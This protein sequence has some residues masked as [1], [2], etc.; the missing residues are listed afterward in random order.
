M[1]EPD[2]RLRGVTVIFDLD[3]TLVDTAH[4]ILRALN[5][6]MRAD[7]LADVALDD[8]RAM[9]GRGSRRLL[10]RAYARNGAALPEPALDARQ[11]AFID[12]YARGIADHSRPFPGAE[13]TLDTLAAS[14]AINA[15]ATNKPQPLTTALI[16][17]LGWRDRFARIVGVGATPRKKPDP[18]HLVT[19]AGGPDALA[20]AIMV[21]DSAT[22]VAA[23]RAANIPVVV[24][25]HGYTETPADNLGADLV[26]DS[27]PETID[28]A[29]TLVAAAS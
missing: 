28:A 10:Q 4:D 27:L 23:A 6:V 9:V 14:G 17:A 12:A 13:E 3:G 2:P 26:L 29:A 5:A 24:L 8:V 21:G 15:L 1:L 20:C 16:D 25:R 18:V 22:D 11:A 7:G 19:A